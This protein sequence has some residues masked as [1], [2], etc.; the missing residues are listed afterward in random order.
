[1]V[2]IVIESVK[3]AQ[4]LSPYIFTVYLKYLDYSAWLNAS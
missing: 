1:M 3:K 4:S 2:G